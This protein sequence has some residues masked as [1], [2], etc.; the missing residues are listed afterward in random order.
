MEIN[1]IET[2]YA[3]HRFRSR[4]EARWAVFFDALGVKWQYEP[5]GYIIKVGEREVPYL[6]DFFL[7]S[8]KTWVEVKGSRD[9]L[10]PDLLEAAV[11]ARRGLPTL[12]GTDRIRLLILGPIPEPGKTW[13]HWRVEMDYLRC[14]CDSCPAAVPEYTRVFFA[15]VDRKAGESFPPDLLPDGALAAGITP[16]FIGA[17]LQTRGPSLIQ[18]DR[19]ERGGRHR[20]VLDYTRATPLGWVPPVPA[21]DVALQAARSARFEHGESGAS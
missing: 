13:L 16:E 7:P 4:L 12:D 19:P 10:D 18:I 1:A 14:F 8:L 5:Q 15:P 17:Q 6:P 20:V 3:G 2:R 21:V 11:D 9:H